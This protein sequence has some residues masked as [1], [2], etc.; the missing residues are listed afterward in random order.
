MEKQDWKRSVNFYQKSTK[1]MY[2]STTHNGGPRLQN[3]QNGGEDQDIEVS[4]LCCMYRTKLNVNECIFSMADRF[5]C[6]MHFT[7]NYQCVFLFLQK[8]CQQL[9]QR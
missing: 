8:C 7:L 2:L 6:K 3:G 5:L 9:S 4:P 1:V